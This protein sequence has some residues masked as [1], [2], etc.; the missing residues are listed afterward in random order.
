[1]ISS[2]VY[3]ERVRAEEPPPA[4]LEFAEFE[5][6]HVLARVAELAISVLVIFPQQSKLFLCL[7]HGRG[8]LFEDSISSCIRNRR[9]LFLAIPIGPFFPLPGWRPF[10][11]D[12][13][14]LNPSPV[15]IIV[16]AEVV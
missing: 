16:E 3:E 13:F 11:N 12:F 4:H 14:A 2:D 9:L 8:G 15:F 5:G 6:A 10:Y 1:M 7:V